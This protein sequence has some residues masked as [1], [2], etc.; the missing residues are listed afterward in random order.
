MK[1]RLFRILCCFLVVIL[2]LSFVACGKP[3]NDN[4]PNH[5]Q[6]QPTNPSEPSNPSDDSTDS[7]NPNNPTNP[8][9][10]IEE[11]GLNAN[12]VKTYIS[13]LESTLDNF[14]SKLNLSSNFLKTND[15]S[16][17]IGI[18]TVPVVNYAY[19]PILFY[20]SSKKTF[21]LNKV[22]AY[23]SRTS[24]KFFKIETNGEEEF[25]VIFITK[26]LENFNYNKFT[27]LLDGEEIEFVKIS[28]LE[29][30]EKTGFIFSDAMFD[31]K[32]YNLKMSY[33]NINGFS[34]T[35]DDDT[36]Y[37][38]ESVKN[39]LNNN[40][41]KE[42]V[43]QIVE[44]YDGLIFYQ[45]LTFVGNKTINCLFG[46]SEVSQVIENCYDDFGFLGAYDEFIEF[47]SL[48]LT[49]YI[50]LSENENYFE[51]IEGYSRYIYNENEF[52]FDLQN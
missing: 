15:Y 43:K 52:T 39:Y 3:T 46:G 37:G 25:S 41:T 29:S 30:H 2:P 16:G 42:K 28:H 40:F 8:S 45:D 6:S 10:P 5:E 22:Y 35:G 27:Y 14:I 32:N 21:E 20:S 1:K 31:L 23:K 7:S 18:N 13:S 4:N 34:E 48:A 11:T 51:I 9:N 50:V 49:D 17:I 36:N 19:S 24:Y 44:N 12:K 26:E 38:F 33:G 47:D